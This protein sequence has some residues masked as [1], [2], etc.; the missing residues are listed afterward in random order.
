MAI[1]II[2]KHTAKLVVEVGKG[3]KRKRKTKLVEYSG[4]RDLERQYR[5]FEDE[6][7]Q[8]PLTDITVE[9]LLT[10]Y[11]NNR[12]IKGLKPT[13]ERGYNIA[14]KRIIS[15]FDGVLARDLTTYHLDEFISE[16]AEK[17]AP[18]TIANTVFLLNA[19]YERAI[20]T[21]Q[22]TH[23]PCAN[24]TLPKK[25]RTEIKTMNEDELI[26]FMDALNNERLDYKVGYELCLLCG[27]RRSEVLGLQESDINFLFKYVQVNKTRHLVDGE[28]IIQTPKTERSRRTLAL[29]QMLIEDI[30]ALIHEHHSKAYNHTDYL[31]QDGFGEPMN[32]S[33]FSS[34]LVRLEEK[35]G[36]SHV[37][38]HGLRHTFATLL[39]AEGVDIAQIS[40]ELGHSNIT[41]TLNTYTHVFGGTTASSRGIADKMN[42]KFGTLTAL[43]EYEKTAEA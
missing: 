43:D 10:S 36:I 6:A 5:A 4:K 13:T 7:K 18:K 12:K 16:M 11:I 21:G 19:A 39:N 31:I 23:N 42:D 14:K 29:P 2:D 32:P 37:T 28:T 25:E 24:A 15:R 38:V 1:Q 35:A 34:H 41:T 3:S 20:K 40:A 33:N 8:T 17:Y 22:L 30:A 27:M 9:N 26:L